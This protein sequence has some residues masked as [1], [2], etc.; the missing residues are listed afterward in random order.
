MRPLP[1]LLVLY[2]IVNAA[3]YCCLLPLWEGFDE[4]YHYGYVQIVAADL[5]FPVLGHASLSREIWHSFELAP[6]SHYLQPYTH[7]PLN[8]SDHFLLPAAERAQRR[9]QLESI[10]PGERLEAQ[11]DKPNYEVN[12]S[13]LAYAFMGAFDRLLSGSPLLT[14][15]LALRLLCAILSILLLAHVTLRLARELGLGTPLVHAALFCV[16]SSQMLY[17]TICHVSNDTLAPPAMGY[18][19]LTAI[20][21]WRRGRNR[22][23]AMFGIALAAA[24][25]IKAYFLF[26]VPMFLVVVIWKFSQ[27][28]AAATVLLAAPWYVRNLLLYHNL[29]A[30]VESTSGLTVSQMFKTAVAVPWLESIRY[31]AHSSLWTGNNSFT[32]FSSFTLNLALL[33]LAAGVV[34]YVWNA[35]RDAAGWITI[36]AILLFSCGLAV[37]T[38][39]FFSGTSGRA[40]AAVPWYSQVLLAPVLLIVFLGF[41]RVR[42]WGRALASIT[43]ALWAYL[44]I[45]TYLAKLIPMYGGFTSPHARVSELAAWYR[46][47]DGESILETIC[48]GNYG[49]VKLLV[50]LTVAMSLGLCV[51]ICVTVKS[52]PAPPLLRSTS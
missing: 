20:L 11:P 43:V 1:L 16:F 3:A 19:L 39:A 2:G 37:V 15:V 34:L 40:I 51:W 23:W 17:A 8:F 10:S 31:M 49:V 46:S 7:A 50:A 24:L 35:R 21:A 25:L 18:V 42:R 29:S 32:T 47:G 12:Q 41:A 5:K 36:A 48:L 33:L 9:K 38:V 28:K 45:A 44:M 13:P 14:R 22:D 52:G 26:V 4:A 27:A 30:T 6:V